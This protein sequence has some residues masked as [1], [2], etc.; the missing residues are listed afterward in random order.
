MISLRKFLSSKLL[1]PSKTLINITNPEAI[2]QS[3]HILQIKN[4]SNFRN[5]VSN[6]LIMS[7]TI[8]LW[9]LM[10]FLISSISP[11]AHSVSPSLLLFFLEQGLCTIFPYLTNYILNIFLKTHHQ[12]NPNFFQTSSRTVCTKVCL[13]VHL[14]FCVFVYVFH[15]N[16][17][18]FIWN[19]L[20]YNK[21]A[22]KW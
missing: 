7:K 22:G 2:L 10:I 20:A 15:W 13:S 14:S 11:L 21:M 8:Y 16:V 9:H 17:W 19:L 6:S 1:Y 4:L 5:I 12:S 3:F 18:A